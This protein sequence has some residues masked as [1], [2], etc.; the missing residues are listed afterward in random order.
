MN[1]A[2]LL[3]SKTFWVNVAAICTA[4]GMAV[5]GEMSWGALILPI[6]QAIGQIC[7]RDGLANPDKR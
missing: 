2:L 3:K 6:S 4:I 7:L 5:G 1:F